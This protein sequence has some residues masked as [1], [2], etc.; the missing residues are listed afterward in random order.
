MSNCDAKKVLTSINSI[1]NYITRLLL[2]TKHAIDMIINDLE[3]E[4]ESHK[5]IEP[6]GYSDGKTISLHPYEYK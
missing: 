4:F 2:S 3:V 1:K 5:I 6:L